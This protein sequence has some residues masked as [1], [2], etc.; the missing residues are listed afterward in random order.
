MDANVDTRCANKQ[1]QPI[2]R[3][4]Q[5]LEQAGVDDWS[6]VYGGAPYAFT[7]FGSESYREKADKKSWQAFKTFLTYRME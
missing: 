1:F 4:I 6:Q 5:T 7:V 3:F 2:G